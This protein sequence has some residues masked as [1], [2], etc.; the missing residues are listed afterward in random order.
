MK[1]KDTAAAVGVSVPSL[2][3]WLKEGRVPAP[4]RDRLGWRHFGGADLARLKKLFRQ[5]HPGAQP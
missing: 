3:R 4:K 2:R 5:L 1:I